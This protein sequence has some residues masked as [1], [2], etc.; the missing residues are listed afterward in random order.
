MFAAFPACRAGALGIVAATLMWPGRTP[1]QADGT[2][3]AASP[4]SSSFPREPAATGLGGARSGQA[5]PESSLDSLVARALVVNPAVMAAIAR[6]R[7]AQAQVGPAGARPDPTLMVG[8][9]NYALGEP[10]F[11]DFMTMKMVGVSQTLPYPGKLGLRERAARDEVEAAGARLAAAKLAVVHDA[12]EAYDDLAFA[13]RALE[14]VRRNEDVLANLITVTTAQYSA[15]TAAQVDVLRARTEAANLA[16]EAAGLG[17][18]R[19]AALARLNA[20]LDRPSSTPVAGIALPAR[21]VRAAVADSA[22]EIHFTSTALGARVAESPL[23]PLDSL[24]ALAI[25]HSPVLQSHEAEIRAQQARVALARTASR[26]DFDV[27][28]QYS[29]R[30]GVHDMVSAVVSLPIPLQRG[31]KQND[32][33]AAAGA[34]LAAREAEHRDAVNAVRAQ[35]AQRVSDIERAR[36]QLALTVKL[37]LPQ[38]RATL[39]SAMT[40]YQVG[41]VP[42]VTVIDAQASAFRS[43]MTYYQALTDFAKGISEL[44]QVVGAEVL[45]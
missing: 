16:A 17:E 21:I 31:R 5:Q 40:G 19:R 4:P 8:V 41:R 42:F 38:A 7:A 23:L 27:S 25:V 12:T 26:P 11:S 28:V 13:E 44:E 36:T 33:S 1:A 34:E 24:Q 18:A 30:Q 10:A 39:A 32:E 37:I 20:V 9:Q 35:I 15:G 2:H 29:Q 45:R 6:M 3:P 43:D 14:I 22:R